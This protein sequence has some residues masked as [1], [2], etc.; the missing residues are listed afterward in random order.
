VI[1]NGALS[2][3]ALVYSSVRIQYL[4][5]FPGARRDEL[6]SIVAGVGD[7]NGDGRGDFLI[8]EGRNNGGDATVRSGM[9]GSVLLD[10]PRN[11]GDLSG[12]L[13]AAALGDVDDDGRPDFVVGVENTLNF[14]SGAVHVYSPEDRPFSS[15]VHRVRVRTTDSQILTLRA[16]VEHAG[17][18][19]LV[20]GSMSGTRPGISLGALTL[21]LNFDA[22]T[23]LL[24]M[25]PNGL[26]LG[27]QG[28]LDASGGATATFRMQ[29]VVPLSMVGRV[30]HHAYI[31]VASDLSAVDFA[32]NA[33]PL[34]FA[35]RY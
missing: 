14:A 25:A 32:S 29:S 1:P 15:D 12:F 21:P 5:S 18:P 10:V 23:G 16:G 26:I 6:G 2:G 24:A 31:V 3:A 8:G 30:L 35:P 4:Y 11:R 17:K 22:Y 19:Y 9:D 34:T 7:V 20:V 33:V 27:S 13:D 28:F